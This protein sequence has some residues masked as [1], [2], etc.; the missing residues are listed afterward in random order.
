M[1]APPNRGRDPRQRAAPGKEA[2]F[3]LWKRLERIGTKGELTDVVIVELL[4]P[5]TGFFFKSLE[6]RMNPLGVDAAVSDN[7]VYSQNTSVHDLGEIVC[8]ITC[9]SIIH[10]GDNATSKSH[11]CMNLL[12]VPWLLSRFPS[13]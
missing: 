3:S 9:N 13:L 10:P 8:E 2:G 5:G 1:A 6:R 11:K 4:A 7:L 12:S